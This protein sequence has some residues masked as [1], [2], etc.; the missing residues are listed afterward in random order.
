MAGGSPGAV[1]AVSEQAQG[2]S[3]SPR[4]NFAEAKT[5]VISPDVSKYG[6]LLD[7]KAARVRELLGDYL[8]VPL[9]VQV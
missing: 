5:P 4:E 9:H 1:E 3:A 6:T 7:E 8:Q 2:G